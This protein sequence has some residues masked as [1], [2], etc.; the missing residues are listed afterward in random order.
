[1]NV[2]ENVRL[3]LEKAR[4][5]HIDEYCS[6]CREPIMENESRYRVNGKVLHDPCFNKKYKSAEAISKAAESASLDKRITG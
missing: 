1:M 6:E 2:Y 5:K 4:M 3:N